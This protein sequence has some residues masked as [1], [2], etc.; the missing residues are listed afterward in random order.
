MVASLDRE[1][2]D[3]HIVEIEAVDLAT[4]PLTSDTNAILTISVTDAND[5]VPLFNPTPSS[6][7][8]VSEG[9]SVGFIVDTYSTTDTDIG[10]NAVVTFSVSGGEG[11]FEVDRITGELKIASQLDRETKNNYILKVA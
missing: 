6:P 4:L 11:G 3:R 7:V 8:S 10:A 2:T 1:S 9:E 5:N